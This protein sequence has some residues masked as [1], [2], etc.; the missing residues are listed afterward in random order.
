MGD[1]K[2]GDIITYIGSSRFAVVS[3]IEKSQYPSMASYWGF[4]KNSKEDAIAIHKQKVVGNEGIKQCG[5][6]CLNELSAK[7]IGFVSYKI[8]NWKERI[9]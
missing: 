8:T 7:K 9:K 5:M 1:I 3:F 6:T 2:L 4:F